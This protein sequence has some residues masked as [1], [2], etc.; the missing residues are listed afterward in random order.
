MHALRVLTSSDSNLIVAFR[1]YLWQEQSNNPRFVLYIYV[2]KY[3]YT[4][5]LENWILIAKFI[6]RVYIVLRNTIYIY[7]LG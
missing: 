2:Y 1:S 3:M 4:L 6:E 5:S 7:S